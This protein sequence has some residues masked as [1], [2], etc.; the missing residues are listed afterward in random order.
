M[1]AVQGA[2]V[3]ASAP[4]VAS[5]SAADL[6]S[7]AGH[8][9]PAGDHP[10][11]NH[12]EALPAIGYD[13]NVGMLLGAIGYYALDGGKDDPLFS[14]TPYRHRLFVQALIS[15]HG[16]R[17]FQLSY[18]GIYLGD[19]PYRLRAG[20]MFERNINANYFGVGAHTMG[21]LTFAGRTHAT[22][23][24]QTAAASEVHDGVAAPRYNHYAYNK[25][26]GA[27]AVERS[28]FGGLVRLQIGAAV[29]HLA[30]ARYDGT[31]TIGRDAAGNDVPAI[32]GPTQLGLDCAAGAVHG[33]EGGWSDLVKAGVALDTR[34][35]EP[36]PRSGVFADAVVGW[37]SRAIGATH[38]YARATAALRMYESPVPELADLVL[39]LR[40]AYSLHTADA[41]FFALGTLGGTE[42]DIDGA[43]G[44]DATLRGY[45]NNRFVGPV[46]VVANAEL[47]WTC[48][49]FA[50]RRQRFA[51]M[52]TP[53]FDAGRA[54]D[55]VQLSLSRW[56][57]DYGGA[58]RVAWN[59]STIIR[60]DV[61]TS[62]ED[63][64]TYL[65]IDLPF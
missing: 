50:L 27:V 54:L 55:R 16:Y 19:S 29:Q 61:A 15:T 38:G 32:H 24:E 65:A 39:A 11:G 20:L 56:R 44:G 52:L 4:A 58:L 6:P 8:K 63:T 10:E 37:T 31:R 22:F 13:P 33:C 28:V 60:L 1:L 35:F 21:P 57:F 43:L 9:Q 42:R 51:V 7:F 46:L 14:V 64:A 49:R 40:L 2:C 41:P 12:L 45:R 17:Q 18:D 62:R 36:D 5:G 3:S 47:R 59:R 48:W 30:I 53:L 26:S 23:A 34:D 25:P